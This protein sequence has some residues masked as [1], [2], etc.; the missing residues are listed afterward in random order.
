MI[1]EVL[2]SLEIILKQSNLSGYSRSNFALP[3]KRVV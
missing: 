1:I 2:Q 3:L